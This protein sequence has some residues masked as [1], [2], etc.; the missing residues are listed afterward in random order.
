MVRA[1]LFAEQVAYLLYEAVL[2]EGGYWPFSFDDLVS[3]HSRSDVAQSLLTEPLCERNYNLP[4]PSTWTYVGGNICE[5]ST[6]YAGPCGNE[7]VTDFS[8]IEKAN[9]ASSCNTHWDCVTAC[10]AHTDWSAPCP[11]KGPCIPDETFQDHTPVMR[12]EWAYRCDVHWP[13]QG[14]AVVSYI[15]GNS[16][17]GLYHQVVTGPPPPFHEAC[18]RN[19]LQDPDRP[20]WCHSPL[21]YLG[22]C[23]RVMDVS[24]IYGDRE[25]MHQVEVICH[26]EFKP[27]ESTRR[28]AALAR[29]SGVVWMGLCP[30]NWR[31][32]DQGFC[33]RPPVSSDRC[34]ALFDSA[35][36]TL[37]L[38]GIFTAV[39][40]QGERVK[41][42]NAPYLTGSSDDALTW[43]QS[44][45]EGPIVWDRRQPH[46]VVGG[47]VGAVRNF[48]EFS[49]V[50]RVQGAEE[51]E[52]VY[53]KY[54]TDGVIYDEGLAKAR[55]QILEIAGQGLTQYR[56]MQVAQGFQRSKG[57]LHHEFPR[58]SSARLDALI[59]TETDGLPRFRQT[60]SR[61][62]KA[63]LGFQQIGNLVEVPTACE[64]DFDK[65]CPVGW[66]PVT[67]PASLEVTLCL[68]E[69][70]IL[71]GGKAIPFPDMTI[72]EKVQVADKFSLDW[73]CRICP[74][75]FV[76]PRCP[77]GWREMSRGVCRA[78][79]KL[80][81]ITSRC[82]RVVAFQY[83]VPELRRI[84]AMSCNHQW[85]CG[86]GKCVR[87]LTPHCP[88]HF[89]PDERKVRQL[90]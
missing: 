90:Q 73:P 89:T 32:S 22:P 78:D 7:D 35:G 26:V 82:P 54:A 49:A 18:P 66:S 37:E 67:D 88:K 57:I 38:R 63:V 47:V 29:S 77:E 53:Q 58:L 64:Q 27:R 60:S 68:S 86:G 4:C 48:T 12:E 79:L 65:P 30:H 21:D 85:P 19:W 23:P 75:D 83:M 39:C 15:E 55:K 56:D 13:C 46:T 43:W 24:G 25:K 52:H 28:Q 11:K 36:Y 41:G 1:L 16:L 45:A 87:S 81:T 84:T 42:S 14:A 8:P 72:D 74:Q 44:G 80:V 70:D 20:H 6:L 9:L 69:V 2:E 40:Q 50:P 76:S 61:S 33:I 31:P 17:P 3:Y 59:D 51:R 34:G 10:P 62:L 71:P 5:P